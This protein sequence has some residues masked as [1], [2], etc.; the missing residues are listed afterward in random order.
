MDPVACL[1]SVESLVESENYS[2]ALFALLQYYSW[3]LYGGFEPEYGDNRA[4]QC[5]R[6]IG[7]ASCRERV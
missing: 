1:D 4:M 3:R 6:Q 2:E 5:H 7:R